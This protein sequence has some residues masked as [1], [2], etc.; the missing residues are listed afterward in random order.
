[1]GMGHNPIGEMGQPLHVRQRLQRPLET[2]QKIPNRTRKDELSPNIPMNVPQ[3]TSHREPEVHKDRHHRNQ[4]AYTA[5]DGDHFQ[6]GRGWG[7][8]NVMGADMGV[9]D[10]D[11]PETDKRQ[12]VA[13][14]RGPADDGDH[15]VGYSHSQRGEEE[16]DDVMAIE[17]GQDRIGNSHERS[18]FRV[19]YGIAEKIGEEGENDRA[20]H[21]PDGH[22]EE[23]FPSIPDGLK[24]VVKDQAQ[25][26]EDPNIDGPDELGVFPILG[27]PHG[28]GEDPSSDGQVPRP[29]RDLANP[30][31]MERHSKQCGDQ[32]NSRSN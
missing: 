28:K 10:E 15:I 26:D 9:H 25:N 11:G 24:Q 8:D 32:I 21:I 14:Q 19:P 2:R 3:S 13:I 18:G 22:I 16:C 7:L 12:G 27:V 30:F 4:H 5:R 17:P 31:T 6:P 29:K 23:V 1:M 20:Q